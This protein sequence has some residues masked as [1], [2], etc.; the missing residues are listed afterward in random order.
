MDHLFKPRKAI[1]D[2]VVSSDNFEIECLYQGHP[3]Y[4]LEK[5]ICIAL[6]LVF[7]KYCPIRSRISGCT[8]RRAIANF[9]DFGQEYNSYNPSAL[10]I[11]NITDLSAEVF[12][13]FENYLREKGERMESSARIKTGLRNAA[14][15]TDA[16]PDIMLPYAS[17]DVHKPRM[18]LTDEAN[19]MLA[20]A[21]TS[22]VDELY[23][24]I[25]FRE[26]V[27][28][29]KPYTYEEILEQISYSKSTTFEWL[30]YH[31]DNNV[32]LDWRSLY[33]KLTDSIDPD[34]R[35]MATRPEWRKEIFDAYQS[36]GEKYI[37]SNP[38]NPYLGRMILRFEPDLAR[39]IKTFLDNGYPFEISLADIDEKY[40]ANKIISLDL[41]K[42][43][44][45]LLFL[46]W[47]S[48][49]TI[50]GQSPPLMWDDVLGLYFPTMA[51]MSCLVQFIMLQTNWNKEAVL[52]IDP[53]NCEHAMTGSM[54]EDYVLLQTE[55]NKSQGTGKPY[56]A[57]K[58]IVAASSRHDKYSAHS[59]IYLAAELSSV[60]QH[61]EFDYI[62]HGMTENSYNPTFLCIRFYGDWVRKGGRHTSASNEKAFQ[63][64]IKQ[65][66]KEYPVYENGERLMSGQDLTLRL[67]PTWV[68]HQKKRRKS[69]H[70]LLALLLGHSSPVTTDVHYDNSPAAQQERFDRLESELEAALTLMLSGHFEGMLGTP[71]QET[72][73]LPFK[74]FHIP[75][76]EKPLWACAN[77]YQP[78]WHGARHRVP[79]GK[80]CYVIS[81]CIYC[82]QCTV[83]EDSLPYLVERRIHVVE[84]IEDQ[85]ESSSDYSNT[86]ETE[87][88][89][90]D[91]ILDNW[92]DD[93]SVREA[94][95]YQRRNAPLLPRDLN[96]LQLILE[97]EDKE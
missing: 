44:V 40:A 56:H 34:F 81:K 49:Y 33:Q 45:Q 3:F 69:S 16:I 17:R 53:E 1:Y 22:C 19:D 80:R 14:S 89:K 91:S 6:H 77:Q 74:V 83:F 8:L 55:K 79:E 31:F 39:V 76:M 65:F 72:V 94:V 57:P 84:L 93:Q 41:C 52:A 68:K 87:L 90:I 67:R 32:K 42:D 54:D 24:K 92:E 50:P 38:T 13:A 2:V 75:G 96:F 46:R 59:L 10:Q 27:N 4:S 82:S 30:Q 58:E 51:D 47:R 73:Q 37:F 9:F 88:M 20:D 85:P 18:P 62:K 63:Q 29:A 71:P 66:L 26:I 11:V 86:Y 28:Q 12:K 95:R 97:E 43:P 21:F 35:S 48:G 5:P 23:A 15:L 7:L 70:G 60:L 64:G 25:E 61:Y 36:R 78:K